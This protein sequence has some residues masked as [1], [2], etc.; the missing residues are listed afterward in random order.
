MKHEYQ[1]TLCEAVTM[2]KGIVHRLMRPFLEK[3]GTADVG[4]Y[5]TK[6]IRNGLMTFALNLGFPEYVDWVKKTIRKV[7]RGSLVLVI[8]TFFTI[9]FLRNINHYAVAYP[10]L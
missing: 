4:D 10:K 7:I 3:I 6:A 8:S 2:F 1:A 5:H 9:V